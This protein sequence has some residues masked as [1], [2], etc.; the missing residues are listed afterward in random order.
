MANKMETNRVIRGNFGKVWVNDDEWM[1]VKSFEAK[2]SAEYEDV[3]IPG[4]F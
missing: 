3:N 4:K 1:N 2:V